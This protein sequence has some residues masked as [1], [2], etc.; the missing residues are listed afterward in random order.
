MAKNGLTG[1]ITSRLGNINAL[2][3][4]ILSNNQLFIIKLEKLTELIFHNFSKIMK[5]SGLCISLLFPL[6]KSMSGS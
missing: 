1:C 3:F 2:R 4:L 5:G 6:E